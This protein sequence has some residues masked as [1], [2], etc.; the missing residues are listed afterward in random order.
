MKLAF[1]EKGRG[2]KLVLC[3]LLDSAPVSIFYFSASKSH[4]IW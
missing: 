1:I 2:I 4:E 3:V